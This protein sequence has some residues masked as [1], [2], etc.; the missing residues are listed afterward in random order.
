MRIGLGFI[1]LWIPPREIVRLGQQAEA[2]GFDS[3][4][5]AE[6]TW[7]T[8]RDAATVL[9]ALAWATERIT[10]GTAIMPVH[11]N[12]HLLLLAGTVAS[13]DDIARGRLI[14]GLGLGMRWPSYPADA[15]PLAFMREAVEGIRALLADKTVEHRGAALRLQRSEG[16]L[17]WDPVPP[18]RS[19]IPI[20]IAARGPKMTELAC[21]LGDGLV[22]PLHTPPTVIQERRSVLDGEAKASGRPAEDVDLV[23]NIHLCVTAD[24]AIPDRLQAQVASVLCSPDLTDEMLE[25][26]GLDMARVAAIRAKVAAEGRG[27]AASLVAPPMVDE[28]CVAGSPER[29]V[30]LLRRYEAAGLKRAVLYPL[31]GDPNLALSLAAA[32]GVKGT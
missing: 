17:C 29:C 3:V 21:R 27:A 9:G 18:F 19:R 16:P 12:R 28:L 8:G 5:L 10:L 2:R 15:K 4:W 13:L 23:A 32:Y 22:L 14:L 30:E 24:G 6:D 25:K 31:G 26:A 7:F 20:Y 1:G 11:H